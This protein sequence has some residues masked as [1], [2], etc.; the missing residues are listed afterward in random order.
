MTAVAQTPELLFLSLLP[1]H[2]MGS[3]TRN[4]GQKETRLSFCKRV[5]TVPRAPRLEVA[6]NGVGEVIQRGASL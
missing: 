2:K 5:A 3:E 6:S 1:L 4:G